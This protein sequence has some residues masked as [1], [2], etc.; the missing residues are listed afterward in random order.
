[1]NE[2]LAIIMPV[3]NEE[4]IVASVLERWI[5]A[6]DALR[7]DYHIHAY[8]DGS[9]DRSLEILTAFAQ[10]HPRVKVHDK[11]N[12]GHGIT[13]LQGYRE[14]VGQ[15][16]WLFQMDSDNEMGPE[17]FSVFWENRG[18][19]DF[20]LG[21]RHGRPQPLSR[22]IVSLVS[23]LCVHIFYG[24]CVWDVNSPYRLM[25]SER[26]AKLFQSTP[27]DTRSPN[28]I[29]SGMAARLKLRVFEHPVPCAGRKTGIV[30]IQ[31]WKLLNVAAR[32]LM[33]TILFS[34]TR[35]SRA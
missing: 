33:Q 3:Y 9:K 32:S 19:Y 8:N 18:Q 25:R 27:A 6:L 4:I 14:N 11:R 7:I 5:A 34:F 12:G 10:R 29:I 31:K 26:F 21:F 35:E 23:R 17:N 13:I 15:Y 22:K 2:T 28:L 16:T 1:M 30:S 20:L 24:K